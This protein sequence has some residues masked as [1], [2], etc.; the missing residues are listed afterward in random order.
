MGAIER[1]ADHVVANWP[2]Y[3]VMVGVSVVG[4]VCWT[5]SA[6]VQNRRW[7]AL[8]LDGKY[9]DDKVRAELKSLRSL[10]KWFQG[11]YVKEHRQLEITGERYLQVMSALKAVKEDERVVGGGGGDGD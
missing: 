10:V 3:V 11:Q 1:L 9:A 5:A 8:V 2:A 6:V 7:R 4:A